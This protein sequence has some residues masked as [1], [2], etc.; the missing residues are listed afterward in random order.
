M[1]DHRQEFGNFYVLLRENLI[2][3]S[4]IVRKEE[5][6]WKNL[7]AQNVGLAKLEAA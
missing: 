3:D 7:A 6:T 5:G 4:N 1:Y 2:Q